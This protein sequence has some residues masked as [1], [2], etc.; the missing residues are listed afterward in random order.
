[1]KQINSTTIIVAVG[2]IALIGAL[3]YFGGKNK[4]VAPASTAADSH[5]PSAGQNVSL[6]SLN[7]ML[8]Q[9]APSFYLTD[10]GGKIYSSDNLKGKNVIL[11]FNEG[12]M[13]YPAC[14][15]QIVSFAKDDRFE[16]NDITV[17]SVVIDSKEDWQ[18]AINKMPELA[19][20]T[21][22]FDADASVAKKFGVLSTPSSMHP[23]SF[24]GHTY[25]A[26]DAAGI[27][28]YVFDDPSMAI[29]NDLLITE[30]SKF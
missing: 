24:P 13:C 26:I 4:S 9:P 21:V 30:V 29:R 25:V 19:E 15:N 20:A 11:F 23:G 27:V 14:W 7:G 17:L 12:L 18:W 28:R 6:A 2:I 10:R 5:H 3:F 1:M 16:A 22:V 8:E